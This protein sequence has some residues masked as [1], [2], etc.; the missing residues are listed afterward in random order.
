M[1]HFR[2]LIPVSRRRNNNNERPTDGSGKFTQIKAKSGKFRAVKRKSQ[3]ERQRKTGQ[4]QVDSQDK[5]QLNAHNDNVVPKSHL[6]QLNYNFHSTLHG[7]AAEP[8]QP[9][10]SNQ[11]P[12]TPSLIPNLTTSGVEKSTQN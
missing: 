11:E 6:E 12:R 7:T 10:D 9:L 1:P 2:W 3:R 8:P 4:S 5:H